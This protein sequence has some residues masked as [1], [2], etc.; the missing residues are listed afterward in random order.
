MKRHERRDVGGVDAWP[1]R[2]LTFEDFV[3]NTSNRAAFEQASLAGRTGA[4]GRG[5]FLYGGNG[6]G[7]THLLNAIGNDLLAAGCGTSVLYVTA[8]RFNTACAMALG[9]TV[10]ADID[11]FRS[12]YA[13]PD[14][15]LFDDVDKV[16]RSATVLREFG[17]AVQ[18]LLRSGKRIIATANV[19]ARRLGDID[20]RTRQAFMDFIPVEVREPELATRMAI[21]LR[22]ANQFMADVPDDVFVHVAERYPHDIGRMKRAL[23]R[24]LVQSRQ[25]PSITLDRVRP[26]LATDKPD[27]GC[28]ESVTTSRADGIVPDPMPV[29]TDDDHSRPV[30]ITVKLSF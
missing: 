14:L 28:P 17:N 9:S 26:L 4:N 23:I 15:L 16:G 13:R 11:T 18:R 22:L 29:E 8:E 12:A 21:L 10:P 2:S 6:L 27:A 3:V 7:K 30:A 1:D 20:A 5:L 24:I 19:P 25:W